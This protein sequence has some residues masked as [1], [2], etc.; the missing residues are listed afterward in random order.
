[1]HGGALTSQTGAGGGAAACGDRCYLPLPCRHGAEPINSTLVSAR[2][3]SR[4]AGAH[5]RLQ[6][7][8][9][10]ADPDVSFISAKLDTTS[11]QNYSVQP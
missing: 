4:Y 8:Q 5:S 2:E 11:I 1:M 10:M 3:Y 9:P 6:S 7:L